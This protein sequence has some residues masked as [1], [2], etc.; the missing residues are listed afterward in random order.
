MESGGGVY[1]WAQSAHKAG[2]TRGTHSGAQSAHGGPWLACR[3]AQ[4]RYYG[5][6]S[7]HLAARQA[8]RRGAG[9][10]QG[11]V[12]IVGLEVCTSGRAGGA[13]GRARR[14]PLAKFLAVARLWLRTRP[15]PPHQPACPG[16]RRRR[17]RGRGPRVVPLEGAAAG[18]G[19]DGAV[20]SGNRA[21]VASSPGL[22]PRA[23]RDRSLLTRGAAEQRQQ[24]GRPHPGG[25]GSAPFPEPSCADALRA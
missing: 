23:C 4:D 5:V 25:R 14:G 24:R 22:P 6:R 9:D 16:G 21:G 8:F 12:H 20:G 3:G 17:W 15:R 19:R 11:G 18:T 10:S 13:Q 1:S 7:A 2:C